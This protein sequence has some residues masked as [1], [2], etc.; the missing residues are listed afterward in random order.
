[1]LREFLQL[2]QNYTNQAVGGWY[3]SEKLDGMRAY[4]DG[5]YSRG[6]L[7]SEVPYANTD[8]D[9]RRLNAPR[10]TGLWSRYAKPI[11]APDWFLDQLP[12]FPL[13]GELYL[14]RGNFQELISIVKQFDPDTR[15]QN[16]VY[17]VFDSPHDG[18]MFTPGKINNPN[19]KMEIPDIRDELSVSRSLT[20][21]YQYFK[22]YHWLHSHVDQTTNLKILT[23]K[24]LPMAT[25]EANSWLH[26]VLNEVTDEG[27][28]GLMLR[29]P[30]A[31][32]TP[33]RTYNLLKVKKL[34]DDEAR[35]L[36]HNPGK[37]KLEG[38][39]GSLMVEWNG[40]VF[41]LSGFTDAERDLDALYDR[42]PIGSQIT[43]RYKEVT[44]D[45]IPKE[46]RYLRKVQT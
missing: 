13:D 40:K 19:C 16:V 4:W 25:Q 9:Y 44:D 18:S 32:W 36:G 27:G 24:R 15:W 23:Q 8:K 29:K 20:P 28:E 14:G 26:E 6:K 33:K 3:I 46:A 41:E 1:M 34:L 42:F 37:G 21:P 5:G 45:G 7:T 43:F 30:E 31:T 10:A 35:V 38:L 11:A 17:M 12:D 39:M 22:V 2:A